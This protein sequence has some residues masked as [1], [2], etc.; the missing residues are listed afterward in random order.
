MKKSL[1]LIFAL[2][3]C[4]LD[5]LGQERTISGKVSSA[6]DGLPLPGVNIVIKGTTIGTMSDGNGNYSIRFSGQYG[7]LSFTFV[8]MVP[9]EVEMNAFS[10]TYD[11]ILEP[12]S[13]SLG[14]VVVTALGVTREKKTLGYAVQ[15]I[16]STQMNLAKDLNVINT[17]SGK[18]AGIQVTSG[19]SGIGSSSRIVIRGNSSFSGNQPLFIVDGT[20]INNAT[21]N[22]GGDGG[23]DYGNAASDI[24]PNNVESITVL[25]GANASALYG[26]RASNGVILITT[27]KGIKSSKKLGIDFT[28]S[29][30]VNKPS[31]FPRL[32]NEYGGGD[33]GSEYYWRKYNEENGTSLTYNEYAKTFSYNYVDGLGGGVNDNW[34][35]SWGARLDAGLLIDQ[36]STGPDSPW[37]SRPDNINAWFDTGVNYEN[38]IAIT[39]SGEKASGRF[40]FTNLDAKGIVPN[41]DMRQNTV[42]INGNLTP[43]DRLTVTTSITYLKRAS[44]N[45]PQVGYNYADIYAWRAREYDVKYSREIFEKEGNVGYSEDSDNDFFG[46]YNNPRSLSRDRIFGNV[47]IN[48][49]LTDWLSANARAG[50]DFYN[51]IRFSSN[52]SQSKGNLRLLKG[53]SFSQNQDYIKELN[54]DVSLNFDKTFGE[55]RLDGLA[56]ANIRNNLNKYMWLSASDLTVPDLYTISNVKGTPGYGMSENEYET[57]SVYFA[58]NGSYRDFLFLGITGRN[59][60]SSTLPEENW[61]YFYPSVSLGLS[62]LD[63][64]ALKSDAVTYVKLR[65]SWAQVGGSTGAYQLQ[66]TYSASTFNGV[67]IFS[68]TGTMPPTGLKPERTTS[69]EFGADMRFWD[70]RL[71]LDLTYY[72][73][74]TVNQILSV[75]TSST[76]GYTSMKLNAGEIENKGIEVMLTGHLL[77]NPSGLNWDIT[78]NWAKNKSMVNS[79][80]GDLESYQ[81]GSGGSGMKTLGIPGEEWGILWGLPYVRN[82]A[83]KII[84]DS[85]GIPKTTSSGAKLGSVTPDWTGGISNSFNY[86][87]INLSFLIDMR[88]GGDIFSGQI[89]HSYPTGAYE[90]TTKDNVRETGLI[91][92]GVFEDGSPNNIR[93]SAQ[94]YFGGSWMWNNHEYSIMDGSYIKFR[95]LVLG[96]DF[97]LDKINWI[98][99]LNL[100][101]VGRNLAILYRDKYVREFGLDPEQGFGGG[102]NGIGFENFQLPTTRNYGVKVSI[103]F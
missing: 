43:S 96:Y 11:V 19:G 4:V 67:A 62:I 95:E 77:S 74:T 5:I 75:A 64:F 102:E 48:F 59:D 55:I 35:L 32:Q 103:S 38:N 23:L 66:K 29:V 72:N 20:P 91:V 1:I 9:Q 88:W 14:A 27:K 63:A 12:A 58:A 15:E 54:A 92:D 3:I 60:W 71:S 41:T 97:N 78:V 85:R 21:N 51:E 24:D 36:W 83:G 33:R 18:V 52:S 81:I 50:L 73:Q 25:K 56:G 26:S 6:E 82:E 76:T 86:K 10:D 8:G 93:V 89:W 100:S 22:N 2:L 98:S 101:L 80:Y 47:G 17:L 37:V 16:E 69:Y 34:P 94:D 28:S 68:P 30:V 49:K 44:D 57:Q 65:G 7:I 84:V 87:G 39:S 79:L 42:S 13:I 99:K 53:G 40:S 45:I 90:I 31:Y 46:Y 61:S 70:N